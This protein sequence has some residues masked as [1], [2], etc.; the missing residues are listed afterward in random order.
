MRFSEKLVIDAACVLI[1][2]AV[3]VVPLLAA[4]LYQPQAKTNASVHHVTA[5]ATHPRTARPVGHVAHAN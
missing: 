2:V 4:Q 5:S 1:A 3:L